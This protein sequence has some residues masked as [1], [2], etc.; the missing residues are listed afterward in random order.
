MYYI[1][2]SLIRVMHVC[3]KNSDETRK[4]KLRMYTFISVNS[5]L[6]I[7]ISSRLFLKPMAPVS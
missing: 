3:Y 1:W 2:V 5:K 6:V 4:F 7:I